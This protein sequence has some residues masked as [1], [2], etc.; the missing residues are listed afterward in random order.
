MPHALLANVGK[1]LVVYKVGQSDPGAHAAASHTGALAGEDQVFDGFFRQT[2]AIRVNRYDDLID[3]PAGLSLSSP[4]RGNRLAI[5]T[6]TGG[7]AG[8]VADVCGMSGFETPPPST[9]NRPETRRT[10]KR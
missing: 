8:L 1:R 10:I 3:L 9:Q 6:H 7:A 4:V 5:L 2:G